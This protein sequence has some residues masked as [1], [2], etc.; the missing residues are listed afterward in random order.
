MRS[1]LSHKTIDYFYLGSLS[2]VI[3]LSVAIVAFLTSFPSVYYLSALFIVL[4]VVSMLRYIFDD[5]VSRTNSIVFAYISLSLFLILYFVQRS[6]PFDFSLIASDASYYYWS[7]I[8]SVL[9]GDVD[10]MFLPMADAISGVGFQIFGAK[11]LASAEIILYL[12]ALLL[13]YKILR[14]LGI[15]ILLSSLLTTLLEMVP[16]DIWISKTTFSE[17]IWQVLL[18]LIFYYSIEIIKKNS[19]DYRVIIPYYIVLL[20]LPMT[21]G[22]AIFFYIIVGYLTL[23]TLWRMKNF[24]LAIAIVFGLVLLSISIHY[25]LHIRFNY[26]VG[27]QY[28]R[29]FPHI[30]TE[31]LSIILYSISTV[32]ILSLLYL[33]RLNLDKKNFALFVVVSSIIFR[34]ITA[35]YFSYKKGVT[36]VSILYVNEFDLLHATLGMPLALL[37]IA[38]LVYIYYQAFRGERLYLLI[39]VVY[40]AFFVP[41]IM[42]NVT[43]HDPHQMFLYWHR[44]Y[45]SEYLLIHFLAL[46]LSIGFIY[47]RIV[48]MMENKVY[49]KRVAVIL[50][51][52]LFGSSINL[53]R[54]H[55]VTSEGYLSDAYRL[56]DWTKSRVGDKQTII[57]YEHTK[58]YTD[59][60]L[61]RLMY[62]GLH[63]TRIKLTGIYGVSA[64]ELKSLKELNK[65]PRINRRLINSSKLLALS[66]Y[67]CSVS[68]E[69]LTLEDR[70][71]FPLFW[72][73]SS[74]DL[75]SSPVVG[76]DLNAC[77][78]KLNLS[79]VADKQIRFGD[80]NE[81]ANTLLGRG[82]H[83][84]EKNHPYSDSHASLVLPDIFQ[85][86]VDYTLEL[87]FKI[88]GSSREVGKDINI[89]IDSLSI[90]KRRLQDN[91]PSLYKIDLPKN[92]KDFIKDG[93]LTIDIDVPNALSPYDLKRG[94][95][96][97]SRGIDLYSIKVVSKPYK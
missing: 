85:E 82:W 87:E 36:F 95:D 93:K 67:D 2:I 32:F 86:G 34:L 15:G 5:L 52:L 29:I 38:G 10:G 20:L 24:K 54:Y 64:N 45:F 4:G 27:M 69:E 72:R 22:S 89:S 44:Y 9:H 66:A 25:S 14:E 71:T 70:A 97:S 33:K 56:F 19:L 79:F 12:S 55:I 88:Y 62:E 58:H 75:D 21:R 35:L 80:N 30:T 6:V 7:G 53:H 26:I 43:I 61:H 31:Q 57:L 68:G 81:I 77:L 8:G 90:Y 63:V 46:S 40:S 92:I 60:T 50:I 49:A 65:N 94:K 51:L 16:L 28:R 13:F 48:Q 23:Y 11:Y 78:Y 91:F 47:N 73:Q 76:Y 39:V 17:P 37:S 42:Q 84:R 18:L 96:K 83:D 1:Q 74:S 3:A 59:R 41:Y